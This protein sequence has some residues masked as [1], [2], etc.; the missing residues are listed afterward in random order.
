MYMITN[1]T[2]T[3]GYTDSPEWCYKLS[4]GSPQVVRDRSQAT[5]VIYQGTVYNLPGHSDF[6]DAETATVSEIDSGRALTELLG[7]VTQAAADADDR[8][9]L[10]VDQEYRLTLLELGLNETEV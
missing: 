6:E 4:S 7:K 2:G 1:S 5:G 8:D 9:E 3:I 10:L